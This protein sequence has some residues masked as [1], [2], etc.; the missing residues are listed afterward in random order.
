MAFQGRLP[1]KAGSPLEPD[2]AGP[3]PHAHGTVSDWL[4]T[5]NENPVL[6]LTNSHLHERQRNFETKDPQNIKLLGLF[7]ILGFSQ[8]NPWCCL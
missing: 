3:R 5:S 8:S 6:T 2:S 4:L 1:E 7:Q